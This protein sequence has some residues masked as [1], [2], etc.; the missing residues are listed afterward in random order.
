MKKPVLNFLINAIMSVCMAAIM[1]TGFLMQFT[2]I[3]GQKRWIKYGENVDLFFMGMDRHQWGKIHLILGFVLIGLLA[4]HLFLHWNIIKNVYKK[5]IRRPLLNKL[6]GLGFVLICFG[7]IL[8]P[9][10]INP[11]IKTTGKSNGK[12]A[13]EHFNKKR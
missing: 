13:I 3:S 10:F 2:L 6:V 7:L 5:L 9:F 8:L 4:L 1:G 12:S 11:E